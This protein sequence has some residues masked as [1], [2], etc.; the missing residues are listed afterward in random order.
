VLVGDSVVLHHRS[1]S[2]TDLRLTGRAL[3]WDHDRLLIAGDKEVHAVDPAT[4]ERTSYHA[5]SGV[6]AML[7]TDEWLVLGFADGNVELVPLQEQAAKP[8]FAFEGVPSSQVVRMIEGPMGTL[9]VGYANGTL[10]VWNLSNGTQLHRVKMHGPVVHLLIHGGVL[11]AASE[12]GAQL[13]VDLSV[14]QVAYCDLLR[15]IWDQVAVIW[16]GGLPARSAPPDQHNC[17]GG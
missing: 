8:A 16:V 4:T 7:R 15:S 3:A 6:T 12:L 10:G 9:I 13:A 5:D 17:A 2:V 11:Y 14:F 1:G